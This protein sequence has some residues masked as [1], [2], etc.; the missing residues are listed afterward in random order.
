MKTDMTAI[1]ESH[2]PVLRQNEPLTWKTIYTSDPLQGDERAVWQYPNCAENSS[3]DESTDTSDDETMQDA[4]SSMSE[5][6]L[7]DSPVIPANVLKT[8]KDD[9]LIERIRQSQKCRTDSVVD[10]KGVTREK[11]HFVDEV[12]VLREAISMLR[13]LSSDIFIFKPHGLEVRAKLRLTHASKSAFTSILKSLAGFGAKINILRSYTNSTQHVPFMQTFQE[14]IECQLAKFDL[15][16]SHTEAQYATQDTGA[17]VSILTLLHLAQQKSRLLLDL[18][19]LVVS[20]SDIPDGNEYLCL[21]YLYDL[22]CSRQVSGHNED[23]E[24][25][26]N[27]FFHCF[28]TY[29]KP[30]HQWMTTGEWAAHQEGFI[31]SETDDAG[32]LRQLWN[33]WYKIES[34]QGQLPAPKFLRSLIKQIFTCGKGVVFLKKLQAV[35]EAFTLH[36]SFPLSFRKAFQNGFQNGL[37][38]FPTLLESSYGHIIEHNYALVCSSLR[39]HLGESC[40]L[41]KA[42]DAI[43]Y[44]YLAK[45]LSLTSLVDKKLFDTIYSRLQYWNNRAV[46][47]ELAQRTFQTYPCVEVERLVVRTKELSRQSFNKY[48]LSVHIMRAVAFDYIVPW[49]IANI[50]PEES[51]LKYRRISTFLMQIRYAKYGLDRQRVK[52]STEFFNDEEDRQLDKLGYVLRYKYLWLV[53]TLNRHVT[54]VIATETERMR[55]ALE[56]AQG[57]DEMVHVHRRYI[58]SVMDQCFLSTDTDA[59]RQQLLQTLDASIQMANI[60]NTRHDH[61]V[62]DIGHV[63]VSQTGRE[64]DQYSYDYEFE[65]DTEDT[66]R[67]QNEDESMRSVYQHDSVTYRRKL[68][69]MRTRFEKMCSAVIKEIECLEQLHAHPSWSL[70]AQS[71]DCKSSRKF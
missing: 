7:G 53:N 69:H 15:F 50:I 60:Q 68:E 3:G 6:I 33:G 8:V 58:M 38:P 31:I 32:D 66:E 13:G 24:E 52:E 42:L 23:L 39:R 70:L 9:A 51:F 14:D 48:Y 20:L 12:K 10:S 44:I 40:G 29:A 11:Q 41:C 46:L 16:L 27:I 26:V 37:I 43:E 36:E 67:S 45:D 61:D 59:V 54:N 4:H 35:S 47:T 21:D 34:D 30:L 18:A 71:L 2:M 28:E 63:T 55:E 5:E 25:L 64:G 56:T 62:Y 49:P 57:I 17:V 19:Q 1:E 65:G 22:V